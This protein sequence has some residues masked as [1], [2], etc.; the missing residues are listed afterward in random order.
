MEIVFLGTGG[1]RINLIKQVRGTGGFRINSQSA[2]IHVDPGPGALIHSIKNRQGPLSLDAII[3]T[4]NH[5]DH[6]SDAMVLIE[7]MASYGLKKR[8]IL[9]GS[10]HVVEGDEEGDRGISKYHQSKCAAVHVAVPGE[11]KEFKTARGQ[12]L[13][14][15]VGMRHE[16]PSA[17]GFRITMDGKVVGHISDTEY[18]EGL[19]GSFSGCDA[20]IVNCMK[21]EQDKYAGHLTSTELISVLR[22]ARPQLCLMTHMGIKMLRL[23]PGKEASRIE[24]ESGVRTIAARDGMRLVV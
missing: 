23:G 2:G 5:I 18:F 14:E 4:H 15:A 13:F 11:K 8:G 3:V 6:E 1:G 22:E 17:F 16:E 21:P 10:R 24:R 7:G 20:L 19:G 9:I 12:F